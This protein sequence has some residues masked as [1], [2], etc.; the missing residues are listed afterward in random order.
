MVK[1]I[2]L[3]SGIAWKEKILRAVDGKIIQLLQSPEWL[4][5]KYVMIQGREGSDS[6]KLQQF[7]T[8]GRVKT[9]RH[10]N[11]NFFIINYLK[12]EIINICCDIEVK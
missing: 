3:K 2:D 8:A 9:M 5:I 12:A 7:V 1:I 4:S 6:E 10:H 11:F